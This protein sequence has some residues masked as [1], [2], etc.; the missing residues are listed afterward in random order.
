MSDNIPPSGF[1]RFYRSKSKRFDFKFGFVPEGD[2][3]AIYCLHH[4]P[5]GRDPDPHKT[6]LF[7]NGKICF[8]VGREPRTRERALQLAAQW[9][10][11]ILEYARTGISQR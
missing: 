2:H 8:V 1:T 11:Y 9:A 6:H 10:E 5:H 4:P 7:S 3:L